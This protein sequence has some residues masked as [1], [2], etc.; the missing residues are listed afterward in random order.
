MP[1][2]PES[3]RSTFN[4]HILGT[5]RHIGFKLAG[6]LKVFITLKMK[7]IKGPYSLRGGDFLKNAAEIHRFHYSFRP[8]WPK[9]G[10]LHPVKWVYIVGRLTRL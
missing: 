3:A 8:G 6:I 5:A 10:K 1:T 2:I 4:V 9:K 7:I